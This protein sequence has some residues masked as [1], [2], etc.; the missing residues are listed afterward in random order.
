MLS[1][2]YK[3]SLKQF[4]VFSD[5]L[6]VCLSACLSS[7]SKL[8]NFTKLRLVLLIMRNAK[9]YCQFVTPLRES[10]KKF[11]KCVLKVTYD[12][13]AQEVTVEIMI[14]LLE[15]VCYVLITFCLLCI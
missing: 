2:T 10:L 1:V 7:S 5:L 6:D 3:L 13:K 9:N 11:K 8:D 4:C 12:K 14:L 15:T